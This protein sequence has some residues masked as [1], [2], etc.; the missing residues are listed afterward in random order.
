MIILPGDKWNDNSLGL[1]AHEVALQVYRDI[2]R[3][4]GDK[5]REQDEI[6]NA[7]NERG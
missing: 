1:A 2:S 6:K 3:R 4:S 7:K 5:L